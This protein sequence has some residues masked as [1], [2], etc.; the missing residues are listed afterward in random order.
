MSAGGGGE[1]APAPAGGDG[2]ESDGLGGSEL[3]GSELGVG[4]RSG[5]GRV[6]LGGGGLCLGE[7]GTAAWRAQLG[8][9]LDTRVQHRVS[10]FA[11]CLRLVGRGT[12]AA[13]TGIRS[14]CTIPP[15]D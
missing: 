13:S 15:T 2:L 7:R 10:L 3:G 1:L 4:V 12:V 8:S 9:P 5:G 11:R 6:M 14:G